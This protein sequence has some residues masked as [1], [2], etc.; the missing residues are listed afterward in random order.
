MIDGYTVLTKIISADELSL[1]WP[2]V[3]LSGLAN[4]VYGKSINTFRDI[5]RQISPE[6]NETIR[7]RR[8]RNV[9]TFPKNKSLWSDFYFDL[10]E[11]ESIERTNPEFTWPMN[12]E[13]RASAHNCS[14]NNNESCFDSCA[15]ADANNEN[16]G[17]PKQLI[18]GRNRA[19]GNRWKRY[20]KTGIKLAIHVISENRPF[21]TDELRRACSKLNLDALGEEAMEIFRDAMPENLINH[22][23]RPSKKKTSE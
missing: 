5:I 21:T 18:E 10:M 8:V 12:M 14:H 23:G 1:R 3:S 22:G 6:G 4:M 19:V 7:G 15:S 13:E 20:L 17:S 2:G 11:V 9:F 16:S